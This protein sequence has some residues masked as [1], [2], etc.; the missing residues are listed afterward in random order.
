MTTIDLSVPAPPASPVPAAEDVEAHI[1]RLTADLGG[2]LG[3]LLM[4]LGTRSGLW[5]ALDGAGP[6]T[7]EQVASQVTVDR[8]LVRE[9]LRAEAAAGYLDYD[10]SND[11][12]ELSPAAAAAIPDGPGAPLVEACVEMFTSMTEGFADFSEAFGSGHGFGWHQRTGGHWHGQDAFTRL[13]MPAELIGLAIAALPDVASAL[14][15][16]GNAADV[17]CGYGTPTIDVARQYPAARVLGIDYHDASVMHAREAAARSGVSNVRF[18]VAAALDLPEAPGHGY[19]LVTFFDSLHDLGDPL[20]ALRRARRSV[21]PT[22][23][24]LLFE[25][26]SGDTVADNLNP[27]GRMVYSISTLICTPNAVSQRTATSSE[28]L[29]AQAGEPTLRA[30]AVAAGFSAVR[31]LDLPLPFNLVLELRP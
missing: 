27:G 16:G 21:A 7:S 15:A 23:A 3:V 26:L 11:T 10:G 25:P 18:E 14:Q 4:S 28:P 1:A 29:G 24:A 12:F 31:R 8:A 30:L 19:D 2:S 13:T 9:W 20:G 17:G 6:V 22:G 5:R